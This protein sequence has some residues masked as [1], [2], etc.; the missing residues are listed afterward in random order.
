MKHSQ[1]RHHRAVVTSI[2]VRRLVLFVLAALVLV[3]GSVACGDPLTTAQETQT[4]QA[5]VATPVAVASAPPATE[6]VAAATPAVEPATPEPAPTVEDEPTNVPDPVRHWPTP[7][8]DSEPM[9]LSGEIYVDGRSASGTLVAFIGGQECGK[10]ESGF[11][12]DRGFFVVTLTAATAQPGCGVPGAVVSFTMN[13]QAV[14]ET[15]AWKPGV[16]DAVVAFSAGPAIAIYRGSFSLVPGFKPL[17]PGSKPSLVVTPYIDGL[18]CGDAVDAGVNL[19]DHA[20]WAYQVVVGPE[21]LRPGCGH[22]GASVVLQL[23]VEGGPNID[24]ATVPWQ[25]LPVVKVP[26]AD[27]R[28]VVPRP[29][30]EAAQ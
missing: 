13:R 19:L 23:Q 11:T 20:R 12:E 8:S 28:S 30:T 18:A 14:N 27:L 5:T 26:N 2:D 3:A 16:Q 15:V 6:A 21:E 29:P 17:N 25:A 22:D 4:A 9:S 24:L 1:T 10:G 7:S